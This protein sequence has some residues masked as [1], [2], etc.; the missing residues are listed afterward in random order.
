M[1]PGLWREIWIL[2]GIAVT[3]LFVGALTGRA[4]LIAAI[5]FGFYIAWTLRYLRSL[6][7]WLQ[8]RRADE[9]PDA[10]G[11]WGEV[12]DEIRK[13]V[14]QTSRRQ[15]QL[16]GMLTRF[17]KAASAMPDA[18]VVLSQQDDIEWAN[19]SA[20]NLLGIRYPRD[21]GVRLFN[22][23]R[24]PDFA[25][26]LQR[27]DYAELFEIVSPE[28]SGLHVS[29]QITPFGSSQKLVVGRDVTHLANLEQ[30]RRHFVANV[31]H[32]LRTP[33]TVLG[34][35]VETLQHMDKI[36]MADLRKHL[37]T[38]HEQSVRMQRLVDDL[39]T[40]SRL[41][42]APPRTKDE[43]VDVAQ[44]LENLKQQAQLL[45]GEQHHAITLDADRALRLLGSR[46][47][48]LSAFSNLINNAVR[49]TPAKGAIRLAWRTTG[50]GAE[51]AVTDT[52]EG[53]ELMHI[54]H[55]TERFYRVDTARSRASGGTGLGLSIVKHVLLRHDA[56]LEIESDVGRGSTFRCVFPASRTVRI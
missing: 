8:D 47:E 14:K 40:L 1:H 10:G 49:Y 29:I 41:E 7:R 37:D 33:L 31:S 16:S 9:I 2:V 4:F 13:L 39:L 22:L 19:T 24:D 17:Q 26:Y 51:F 3:S 12:F 38:M 35:Y 46:E 44:L 53:I 32:E 27:G 42:T 34:G 11:M 54:P 5:G 25:Q 30:M 52:G 45:S 21:I 43:S 50:A 20:E 6:H 55:L 15:D 28:N 18:V 56:S 23:L 48:L 36:D